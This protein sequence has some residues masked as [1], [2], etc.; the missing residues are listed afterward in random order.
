[1]TLKAHNDMMLEISKSKAVDMTL[2]DI[3]DEILARFSKAELFDA[4]VTQSSLTLP[5]EE[6]VDYFTLESSYGL[7]ENDTLAMLQ[8]NQEMVYDGM[9][10]SYHMAESVNQAENEL[11]FAITMEGGI[12]NE[13][14]CDSPEGQHAQFKFLDHD[15][16]GLEDNEIDTVALKDGKVID[17][18]IKTMQAEHSS[19]IDL[20]ALFNQDA[21]APTSAIKMT[22]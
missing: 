20:D 8:Y 4:I 2:A 16:E 18:Y 15:T 22:P 17:V 1:M 19:E 13:V 11:K 12:I 9:S 7:D 3:A 10:Y 21:P 6:G 14:L 5:E